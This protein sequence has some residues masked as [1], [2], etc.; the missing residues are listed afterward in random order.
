MQSS[1]NPTVYHEAKQC[2]IP[3]VVYTSL[4]HASAAFTSEIWKVF[5]RKRKLWQRN[6]ICFHP[7]YFNIA[8]LIV[9]AFKPFIWRK[10]NLLKSS[11]TFFWLGGSVRMRSKDDLSQKNVLRGKTQ[12]KDPNSDSCIFDCKNVDIY[13][14][15]VDHPCLVQWAWVTHPL[16]AS[17]YFGSRVSGV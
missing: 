13:Q 2:A 9:F 5:W 11:L 16:P 10:G 14:W 1:N 15:L 3:A 17:S 8:K 4:M 6:Q 7:E 12:I